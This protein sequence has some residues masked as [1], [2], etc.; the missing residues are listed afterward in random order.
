MKFPRSAG[1]SCSHQR[2]AYRRARGGIL[3]QTSNIV[4]S[5]GGPGRIEWEVWRIAVAGRCILLD[6]PPF[7]LVRQI[8]TQPV[9]ADVVQEVRQQW[10]HSSLPNRLRRG[11]RVAV[12]V[13]SRG[14][15]NI[16]SIVRTTLEFLREHG[17]D[18]FVVAA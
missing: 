2:S 15:A 9:V 12:A 3:R 11:Q 5:S 16:A 18:P 13:G 10:S 1:K 7:T 14:I 8:Q 17:T 4:N 6:L